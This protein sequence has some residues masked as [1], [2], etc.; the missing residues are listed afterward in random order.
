MA[1]TRVISFFLFLISLSQGWSSGQGYLGG[2]MGASVARLTKKTPKISYESGV[3]IT[4][5]YPLTNRRPVAM[6][7]NLHGGYE[8]IGEQWIPDIAL[9]VAGYF[10][11][12]D[13]QFRGEGDRDSQGRS[14]QHA[15]QL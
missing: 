11:P 1:L 7:I 15:L 4:D 10:T 5:A 3:L 14:Q 8:F 12:V 9:G 6:T 13:Y 2:E